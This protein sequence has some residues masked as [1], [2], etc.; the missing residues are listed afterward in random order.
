[1]N[2]KVILKVEKLE[3]FQF[4][5]IIT[6]SLNKIHI[7]QTKIFYKT[8]EIEKLS[9]IYS[10]SELRKLYCHIAFIEGYKFMPVFP[11]IYDISTI[12]DGLTSKLI[13]YF[14]D[15]IK[16]LYSQH[17]FENKRFDWE[18]PKIAFSSENINETKFDSI[19][20]PIKINSSSDLPQDR[21]KRPF[22][23]FNGGGKDSF[24]AM[25]LI[26]KIESK[27][28]IFSHARTEYGRHDHQLKIQHLNEKYLDNNLKMESHDLYVIDDF[29]DGIFMQSYFPDIKGE[30]S[31]GFPCQVGFPEMIFEA[32][33]YVLLNGY[34][35]GVLGNERS[36][37]A[38]QVECEEMETVNH[39]YL[40]S[41]DSEKYLSEFIESSLVSEFSVFSILRPIHDF[42]IYKNISKYPEILR[43]INSCNIVKPWCKECSK[44]AYVW[45][46]LNAVFN[47]NEVFN[48]FHENLFDKEVLQIYWEQLLGL[49]TQNAFECV[50]EI[51][52]TRLA[53]KKCIEK[54]MK[55]KAITKF[56][57]NKL[58][59]TTNF[60][61]LEK[62]Y[63]EIYST[64]LL[65]PNEIF[66]KLK[67]FL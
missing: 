37:N 40:K 38:T 6:Y 46:N 25:K 42:R 50:G 22:I 17:I 21:N 33:P 41:Y 9:K 8:G 26:E 4:H 32:L 65:I 43:D 51:G 45:L 67:P 1:M 2:S 48:V 60:D 55:G 12:E 5:L 36:A 10:E 27:Y 31:L 34:S 59:E 30:C 61:E 57:V 56:M 62:K 35:Y 28:S 24:L 44:C 20:E 18:G 63:D 54:G 15:T 66:N 19:K 14:K 52:E 7:F 58:L 3:I 11:E 53:F 47:P 23:C 29:T 39:Q 13:R 49:S 16:K 64:D